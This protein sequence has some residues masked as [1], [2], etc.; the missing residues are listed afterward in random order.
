MSLRKL[1]EVRAFQKP[2]WLNFEPP[3]QNLEAFDPAVVAAADGEEAVISIYGQIGIDPF[4]AV[5]NTER[6]ISAAL[7][8]IGKRDVTV[9]LNSPGG[10]FFSGLA[11]YNLLRAHAAKVTVQ[12]IAMAGSAA[13]VIAMAGD[14]TLMAD[15]SFIMV[16][17]ASALVIGNKYDARDAAELLAEVDEAMAE[18]YAARA[19][20]EKKVAAG[21]MDRRRGDGTM[22]NAASAIENGL[23]DGK[24]DNAAVKVKADATRSIPRE[25]IVENALIAAA[26]LSPQ[27]A[28]AFVAELKSGTRDAPVN[29]T[30]DAD[31]LR[32]AIEQLRST[33]RS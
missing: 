5:D 25:R 21:W 3:E 31:G 28:K 32:A 17:N 24:L 12:V 22:F 11:I 10:N 27:E 4:S 30:R 14:E 7:R 13:S 15:G 6:R 33:I 26:N 16:H 18:I 20:V 8:S 2:S 29:V 1:P 19:G 23:A 9:S